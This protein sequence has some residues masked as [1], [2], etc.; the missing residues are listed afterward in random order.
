M[1]LV[2]MKKD[3]RVTLHFKEVLLT[4]FS[5]DGEMKVQDPIGDDNNDS[6]SEQEEKKVEVVVEEK[7]KEKELVSG[8]NLAINCWSVKQSAVSVLV[9]PIVVPHIFANK[10]PT[11]D[12]KDCYVKILRY[13]NQVDLFCMAVVSKLWLLIASDPALL[14]QTSH[15]WS[16]SIV[17]QAITIDSY[18]LP[19]LY[20]PPPERDADGKKLPQ[21]EFTPI[22]IGSDAPF[23]RELF[24][25]LYDK[26]ESKRKKQKRGYFDYDD[27]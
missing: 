19:Q 24:N 14:D 21:A 8:C 16:F 6:D 25:H 7:P 11:A 27:Y 15:D 2:I 9:K 4:G 12:N 5:V 23:P 3:S 26:G 20:A 13:L 18:P 10:I 1:T 22:E 17:D